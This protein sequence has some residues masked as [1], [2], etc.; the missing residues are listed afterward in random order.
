MS[1]INVLN[2]PENRQ[3]KY[4]RSINVTLVLNKHACV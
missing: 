4:P 2:P 1:Q 3:H